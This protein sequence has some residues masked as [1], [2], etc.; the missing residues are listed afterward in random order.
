MQ[1]LPCQLADIPVILDLYAAARALQTAKGMVVWPWFEPAFIAKEIAEKR[2][3]KLLENGTIIGNWAITW[4][5][6]EIWGERDQHDAVYLHRICN[7]PDWRGHRLIDQVT[8]WAIDYA[9]LHHKPF[10]RLDTLGD[11]RALIHHYTSAGYAFLGMERLTDTAT[12]PQHYQDE[13][14]CCR[15]ER[16]VA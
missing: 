12:L 6:P 8:S 5:D 14:H 15:F 16:A 1:I 3:W 9:R 7:H 13:P 4:Q 11:N 10:V 2:Q